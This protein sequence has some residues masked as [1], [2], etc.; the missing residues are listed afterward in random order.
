MGP[1]DRRI[2][3][4]SQR[5]AVF[6]GGQASP[7]PKRPVT[8]TPPTTALVPV[9]G[10][11]AA[12][13]SESSIPWSAVFVGGILVGGLYFLSR[14]PTTQREWNKKYDRRNR[15]EDEDEYETNKY[16]G[17]WRDRAA[18]ALGMKTKRD[19]EAEAEIDRKLAMRARHLWIERGQIDGTDNKKE[20]F[21]DGPVVTEENSGGA[22]HGHAGSRFHDEDDEADE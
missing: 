11:K 8:A 14:G 15:R 3:Y 17:T 13:A 9:N 22:R 12:G 19:D 1:G 21:D 10:A 6:G 2:P 7:S 16:D 18:H 5:S 4:S 20:R